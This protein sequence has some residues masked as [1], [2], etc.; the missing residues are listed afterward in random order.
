MNPPLINN[1]F[2][3]NPAGVGEPGVSPIAAALCNAII[4]A[5]R[6]RFRELPIGKPTLV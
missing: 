1:E 5:T 6:T 3:L 2:L 4:A